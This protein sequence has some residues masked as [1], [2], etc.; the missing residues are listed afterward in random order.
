MKRQK[1]CQETKQQ[2]NKKQ[3]QTNKQKNSLPK[4]NRHTVFIDYFKRY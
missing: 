4:L 1:S 3:Q 2:T